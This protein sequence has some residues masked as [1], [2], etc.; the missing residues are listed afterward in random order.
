[1]RKVMGAMVTVFLLGGGATG[2]LATMLGAYAE[3]AAVVLMGAGLLVCGSM[4]GSRDSVPQGVPEK[5]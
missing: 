3:G 5:A 4:I 2:V 1:M